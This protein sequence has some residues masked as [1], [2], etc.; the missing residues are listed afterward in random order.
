LRPAMRRL[1]V[2]VG[3]FAVIGTLA[4]E[5]IVILGKGRLAGDVPSPT[6][7]QAAFI[8][9]ATNPGP[10]GDPLLLIAPPAWGRPV[11]GAAGE[12][13]LFST[14]PGGVVLQLA[15]TGLAPSHRYL[16]TL[17][18]NPKL[19]GNDRLPDPVPGLP[20][21]RYF[22]FYTATTDEHGAYGATFGIALPAG[23]YA[24]RFYVKDT[25]DFKIV[26]YHDYF[27]YEVR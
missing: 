10:A 15:L 26:L 6:P 25:T 8:H 4:A 11:P 24:T 1:L 21:E 17:N 19:A 18:G 23:P 5:P 9:A 14:A 16:L 12:V 27:P 13:R 3:L 2:V 22:D 20:E 7:A